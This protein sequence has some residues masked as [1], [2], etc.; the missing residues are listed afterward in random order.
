MNKKLL[1]SSINELI[2]TKTKSNLNLQDL[3]DL[4]SPK[5]KEFILSN[6]KVRVMYGGGRAGKTRGT[7]VGVIYDAHMIYPEKSGYGFIASKTID[8]AKDLYLPY[9][10]KMAEKLRLGWVFKYK[11]NVIHCYEHK[12]T[13]KF[14]S[15]KDKMQAEIA[16]GYS[17]KFV[18]IDEPQNVKID[19]LRHFIEEVIEARLVDFSPK[20]CIKIL[21][22]PPAYYNKY[23]E[24]IYTNPDHHIIHT[25]MFDNPRFNREMIIREITSIAKRKGLTFEQSKTDPIMARQ[26]WGKIVYDNN[27][28]VFSVNE[29]NFYDTLPEN[30]PC[31]NVVMGMDLGYND[32]NAIV[33]LYYSHKEKNIYVVFEEV[34][35]KQTIDRLAIVAKMLQDQH[36]VKNVV[37]DTGS[38]GAKNI[39]ETLS[40]HYGLH[41]V[42]SAEKHDKVTY[43]KTLQAEMSLGHVKF[44]RNSQV[45]REME[46]ILW[47]ERCDGFDDKTGI[48]SDLIDALL[49]SFRYIYNY[50]QHKGQKIERL[51]EGDKMEKEIKDRLQ[52]E[53]DKNKLKEAKQIRRRL[54]RGRR[55]GAK[56]LPELFYI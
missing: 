39:S 54:R 51:S 20:S 31:W 16:Q 23:L 35:K 32:G 18:I 48:H 53:Y 38:G 55:S 46:Q 26:F 15:L 19:V 45:V 17:T 27:A 43:I 33:I 9:I 56:R 13:I 42:E 40:S 34:W 5:Q 12:L 29:K 47:N 22:N 4:L 49:Y 24:N 30:I 44:K 41:G 10:K 36:D 1:E 3:I 11:D 37:I 25:T 52:K 2:E 21:G 28:V 14:I 50:I 8:K 7:A 6:H